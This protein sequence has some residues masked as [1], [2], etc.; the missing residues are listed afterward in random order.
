MN[1][2]K[3]LSAIARLVPP[4]SRAADIG[5]DHGYIPVW[6]I[7][8]GVCQSVYASDIREG[9]LKKAVASAQQHGV[10]D[11][12]KFSLSAGLDGC[13]PDGADT[14]IIA[15]MGGET[16]IE[17]LAAAPWAHGKSLILQPQ[18]KVR[19][20][21]SWLHENGYTVAAAQLVEDAGRIYLIWQV[22]AGEEPPLTPG[23]L[24]IDPKIERG[25]LLPAYINTVIKNLSARIA[26]LER[27]AAADKVELNFLRRARAELTELRR[28]S[29]N[30]EGM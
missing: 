18:T 1:L 4:G 24:Y 28:E 10:Y 15:G 22:E 8:N 30:A 14:I 2:S 21:R 13:P 27:A 3:R 23:Q 16:M 12:I 7:E 17:I 26:G 5:T 11:K 20:L 6:L 19:Q 25:G 29:E 9:P